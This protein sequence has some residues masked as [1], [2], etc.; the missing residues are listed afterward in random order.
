MMKR[1]D[2]ED[3]DGNDDDDS[4]VDDYDTSDDNYDDIAVGNEHLCDAPSP[5]SS[6]L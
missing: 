1:Y 3:K 4:D 5:S 2:D 6:A